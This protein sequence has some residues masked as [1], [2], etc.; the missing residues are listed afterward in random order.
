LKPCP[1]EEGIK[2]YLHSLSAGDII[3]VK[4]CPD[5]EGIKTDWE[6]HPFRF[7]KFETLP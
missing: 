7:V 6:L 4:P 3:A 1:D 2:T 5:E